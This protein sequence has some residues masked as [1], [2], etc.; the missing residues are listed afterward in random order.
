M[1]RCNDELGCLPSVTVDV[2]DAIE[3]VKMVSTVVKVVEYVKVTE[4]ST[5]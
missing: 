4:A 5:R 2:D 3:V 1:R